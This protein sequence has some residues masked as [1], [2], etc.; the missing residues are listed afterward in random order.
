MMLRGYYAGEGEDEGHRVERENSV[1]LVETTLRTD[2]PKYQ[3]KSERSTR[4][5]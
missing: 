3:R 2:S 1:Q 5:R 4:S